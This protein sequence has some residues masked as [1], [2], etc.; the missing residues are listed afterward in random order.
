MLFTTQAFSAI[1]ISVVWASVY[2]LWRERMSEF[3][4]RPLHKLSGSFLFYC[5]S[6]IFFLST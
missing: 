3:A 5:I 1:L 4:M 2:I 6:D